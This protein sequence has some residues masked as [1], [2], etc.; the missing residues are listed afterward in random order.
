MLFFQS[1]SLFCFYN[2]NLVFS[3]FLGLRTLMNSPRSLKLQ[4]AE[5]RLTAFAPVSGLQ[6]CLS[7]GAKPKQIVPWGPIKPREGYDRERAVS[8]TTLKVPEESLQP[9]ALKIVLP[10][11][12]DMIAHFPLYPPQAPPSSSPCFQI[13]SSLGQ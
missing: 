4:S 9:R 11:S 7:E 13:N 6:V 3:G 2:R 8:E 1:L 5:F 12:R 10:G